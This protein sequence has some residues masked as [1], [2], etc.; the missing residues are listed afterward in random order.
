MKSSVTVIILAAGLGTRMKSAK[1]KVLHEASGDTLLNHVLRAALD[2]ARAEEIVVVVGHQADLVKRSVTVKGI[3]FVEQM[4]QKGTGDAVLCCRDLVSGREG[5]LLILNGDGPL[6]KP[7]TLARLIALH[8]SKGEGGCIISTQLADP[9]GYGRIIRDASGHVTAVVEQKSATSSE[10]EI[11]EINTGVYLFDSPLFWRHIAELKPNNATGEYYLTDMVELL[12]R[13]GHAVSP[14]LVEDKTELLGIN[15]RA[16][17]AIA[18][19]I[20]R[21][22]KNLEL[23]LSGVTIENPDSVLIDAHVEV[24]AD[25]II[26]AGVQLR[27]NTK[28]GQDCRIGTGSVLRDCDIDAGVHI[29]P[30]VVA[31]D[32]QIG[33]NAWVGPFARL[34]QQSVLGEGV[35]VGNFVELKKTTMGAQAKANHLTYLGDSTIGGG[36]NIGAGT[37]TCNYDGLHKHPTEIGSGVFVGSNS[38]LVAPLRIGHAAY[39]AAG[40]VITDDVEEE[41]LAIGRER[42]VTKSGWV[43]KR[44]AQLAEGDKQKKG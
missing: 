9:T 5:A 37:I 29:L 21:S 43:R 10:L 28:I 27:G 17:L 11:S 2:V 25:S 14:L 23:M 42:Q 44:R 34:R 1:A 22:R 33:P 16:E 3:R 24:G 12:T 8:D 4:E 32:T 40:S 18:D 26:E 30:Y 13:H 15:T 19:G 31:Q 7:S 38:T 6:L 36:T 20:L 39:I 35:H 41:A